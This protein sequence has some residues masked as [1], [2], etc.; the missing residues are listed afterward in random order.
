MRA[1]TL[2]HKADGLYDFSLTDL[3]A[4]GIFACS[5]GQ[6]CFARAVSSYLNISLAHAY[7]A[8]VVITRAFMQHLQRDYEEA[9]EWF[10]RRMRHQTQTITWEELSRVQDAWGREKA[11]NAF[12]GVLY[13]RAKREGLIN[14]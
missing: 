3:S 5:H 14:V 10:A 1:E 7:T 2:T 4:K 13:N 12:M 11:L 6:K 8:R 9:C